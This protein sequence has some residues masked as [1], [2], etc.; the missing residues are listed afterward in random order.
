M[1]FL[2]LTLSMLL[3]SVS[4][5]IYFFFLKIVVFYFSLRFCFCSILA[6]DWMVLPVNEIIFHNL[7]FVYFAVVFLQDLCLCEMIWA[8]VYSITYWIKTNNTI[9]AYTFSIL[10]VKFFSK[11]YY[12]I[13]KGLMGLY[14]FIWINLRYQKDKLTLK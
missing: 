13:T 4:Y 11:H 9:T 7:L 6:K 3:T 2:L 10:Y 5:N 14:M 1:N 12:V 8:S